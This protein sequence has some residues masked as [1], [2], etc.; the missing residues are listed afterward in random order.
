MPAPKKPY[1]LNKWQEKWLRALE[2]KK[3]KKGNGAL[4][5]RRDDNDKVVGYCCLGVAVA[6]CG[7]RGEKEML[8]TT[9]DGGLHDFETTRQRLKLNSPNGALPCDDDYL[10]LSD[11]DRSDLTEY[12]DGDGK[13][14]PAWSHP[15]IAAFIRKNPHKVFRDAR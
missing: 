4:V 13:G 3:Y 14:K 6:E 5:E 15:K 9:L 2:T 1:K 8:K 11:K 7:S 10:P 12:N